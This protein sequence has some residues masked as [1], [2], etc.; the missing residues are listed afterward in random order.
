LK[1]RQQL[2][3][4]TGCVLLAIISVGGVGY[5]LVTASLAVIA[6]TISALLVIIGLLVAF[7]LYVLD[8]VP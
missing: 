4:R 2:R 5:F 3:R 1:R 6:V 8:N 7:G